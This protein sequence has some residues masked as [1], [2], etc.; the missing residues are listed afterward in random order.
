M[1]KNVKK[2]FLF[3]LPRSGSTLLQRIL[4]A[5]SK[6]SSVSEPWLLLPFIYA[7]KGGSISEYSHYATRDGLNDLIGKLPNGFDDYHFHLKTFFDSIYN[8]LTDDKSIYFLDKTPRY[9][10][11][12]PEIA[13]LYPDAKFVFLFRNP[14]QVFASMLSMFGQSNLGML[15][16]DRFYHDLIDVPRLLSEGYQNLKDKAYAIQYEKL[17]EDPEIFLKNICNYLELDYEDELLQTFNNQELKGLY[18]DVSGLS[19]YKNNIS[20]DPL[21]KWKKVFN[22]SFRK[23]L[24]MNY[25]K[26][27][28]ETVLNQQGYNRTAMLAEISKLKTNGNYNFLKDLIQFNKVK[29]K[30]KFNRLSYD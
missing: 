12:I 30:S 16:H 18:G 21:E 29:Y 25:V 4:A 1:D 26:G 13:K 17:I 19:D 20:H 3:S 22:S 9:S 6:I 27:L 28:D 15:G 10:R 5:H 11:I 7:N 8:L 23:K 14:V 24:I 2:I